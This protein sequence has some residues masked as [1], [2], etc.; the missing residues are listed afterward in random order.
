MLQRENLRQMALV[1]ARLEDRDLGSAVAEMQAAARGREAAGRLHA[2]RSAASTSR[3]GRRSASCCSSSA[4]AAALV[5]LML[6]V[7]FRRFTPALPDPRWR[8][9]CRSAA[10]FALLL[11]DAAPS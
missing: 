6:V 9:R 7:Q 1:T 4:I 2:R 10:R 5:F 8:R 3:S 11:R